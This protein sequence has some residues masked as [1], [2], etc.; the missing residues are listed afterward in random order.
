MKYTD[1]I[2]DFFQSPKWMMNLLLAAVCMLI[3]VIGPI[4]LPGWLIGGFWGRETYQP[5]TFPEF[6]FSRFVDYLK[7]GL[8]PFLVT[9]VVSLVFMPV[10]WAACFVPLIGFGAL[11]DGHGHHH[12]SGLSGLL[13]LVGVLVMFGVVLV[14]SIALMLVVKPLM[15]RATLLQDFGA[16]FDFRWCQRFLQRTWLESLLAVVFIWFASVVLSL[17]GMLAFCIGVYFVGGPLYFAMVH[18][19]RQLYLLFLERGGDA[20]PLSPSLRD[21]P[22]PVPLPPPALP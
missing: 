9:M 6:D 1:S 21:G 13:A 15:I 18:L 10:M 20:I 12:G 7:R 19:D 16:A 22:P 2:R 5:A 8:W 3:P 17:I 4:V 14:L 11:A